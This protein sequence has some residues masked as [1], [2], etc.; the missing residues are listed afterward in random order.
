MQ[1]FLNIS[2]L[3][4]GSYRQQAAYKVLSSS[5]LMDL[6]APYTPILVGTIPLDI[7]LPHSDL[8][9]ACEVHD[10][11]SFRLE[12][13]ARLQ[14]FAPLQLA[15]GIINEQPYMT[16]SFTYKCFNIEIFGQP[17]RTILQH[18][19]RHMIVEWRLLE[20]IGENGKRDIL[21]MKRAGFKT[22]PAFAEYL[23]L[24]GNP[25]VALLM[26]ANLDNTALRQFVE[27]AR[28]SGDERCHHKETSY[29]K[30]R[31]N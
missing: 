28:S 14:A 29:M 23:K 7:D 4:T 24:T 8:D 13:E 1:K 27:A 31:F 15:I 9:I 6:L 21:R 10:F 20:L 11:Y 16:I 26:L 3:R 5:I 22:E 2:Y 19:Y 30:K 25:Y 12:M 18:S 17:V